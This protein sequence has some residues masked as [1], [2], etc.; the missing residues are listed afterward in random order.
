VLAHLEGLFGTAWMAAYSIY[1]DYIK[2]TMKVL[3]LL[4]NDL[5]YAHDCGTDSGRCLGRHYCLFSCGKNV[6]FD[7]QH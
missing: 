5:L 4:S 6:S 2:S 3:E 1:E 7:S